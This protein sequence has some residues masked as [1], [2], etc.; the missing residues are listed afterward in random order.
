MEIRR[1]KLVIKVDR[2]SALLSAKSKCNRMN[3]SKLS[4]W[5]IDPEQQQEIILTDLFDGD[6]K[7]FNTFIDDQINKLEHLKKYFFI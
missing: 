1:L 5:T 3:I 7:R 2:L 4:S 6:I